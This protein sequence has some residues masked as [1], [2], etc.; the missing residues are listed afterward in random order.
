VITLFKD[1]VRN[2]QKTLSVSVIQTILLM[3]YR[4][5]I[6]VYSEIHTKHRNRQCVREVEFLNVK[7]GGIQCTER[8][9]CFKRSNK[10][11]EFHYVHQI[12]EDSVPD[13]LHT[14][15]VQSN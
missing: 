5:I 14:F 10:R 9:L 6:A 2:A 15:K 8:P 4:E 3:L 11:N 12:L 1:P 13:N 7:P